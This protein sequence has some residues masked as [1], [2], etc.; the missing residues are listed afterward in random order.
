[1][2]RSMD[3]AGLPGEV[4]PMRSDE[5]TDAVTAIDMVADNELRDAVTRTWLVALDRGGY[6]SLA[7]VPQS[8]YEAEAA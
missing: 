1:M 7:E 5:L 3:A 8:A 4:S 6:R 2:K